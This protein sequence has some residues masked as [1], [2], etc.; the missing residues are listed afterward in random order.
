MILTLTLNSA[1]VGKERPRIRKNGFVYTPRK[2]QEYEKAIK[3]AFISKYGDF[4]PI[5]SPI[6]ISIKGYYPITKSWSKKKKEEA[7][8]Q[9][10]I[11]GKP[12]VDNM[13]K[14]VLDALNGVVYKDDVLV[15]N[16]N[17]QKEFSLNPR[18]EVTIKY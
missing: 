4:K 6:E 2:T 7:L 16:L 12:D 13:A 14:I 8:R 10:F 9:N 1:P 3:W 18:I 15:K 17:V 5:E 11:P